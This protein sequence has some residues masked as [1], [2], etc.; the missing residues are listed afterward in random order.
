VLGER[1][2]AETIAQGT[3]KQSCSVSARGYVPIEASRAD[4]VFAAAIRVEDLVLPFTDGGVAYTADIC[5]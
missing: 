3:E 5:G 1:S 4:D 2:A